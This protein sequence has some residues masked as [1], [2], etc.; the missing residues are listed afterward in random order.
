MMKMGEVVLR[1]TRDSLVYSNDFSGW[2]IMYS[3]IFRTLAVADKKPSFRLSHGL[4]K[5]R[6]GVTWCFGCMVKK[7]SEYIVS[8]CANEPWHSF[9]PAARLHE[10]FK[11]SCFPV[12]GYLMIRDVPFFSTI[13]FFFPCRTRAVSHC[14][15]FSTLH[16]MQKGRIEHWTRIEPICLLLS[17]FGLVASKSTI[18]RPSPDSKKIAFNTTAQ[19]GTT[20]FLPCKVHSLG[21]RSVSTILVTMVSNVLQWKV[22]NHPQ[23]KN[24][25]L[26]IPKIMNNSFTLFVN[27]RNIGNTI[28][29][30]SVFANEFLLKSS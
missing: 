6:V 11:P 16:R 25:K 30:N 24:I 21:T 27:H 10:R 14:Y 23:R 5:R 18:P 8:V 2:G 1:G 28:F 17:V 20:V 19:V 7:P 12:F 22:Y 15:Q 26:K 3:G 4:I 13:H 9:S 29:F